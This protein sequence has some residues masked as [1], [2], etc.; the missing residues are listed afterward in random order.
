MKEEYF[1]D[2]SI[3]IPYFREAESEYGDWIDELIDENRVHTNGIV[4]A[5]LLTGAGSDAEFSRLSMALAG[6]KYIP[7]GRLS[8]LA[9]GRYGFLLKRKGVSA[10]LS[11]VII[12]ADCIEH[13]LILIDTDKHYRTISAHFPLKRATRAK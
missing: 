1:V 7:N 11:D 10:P 3:W 9:A 13:G 2:T 5:E 12:A 4:L 6:L 8:F